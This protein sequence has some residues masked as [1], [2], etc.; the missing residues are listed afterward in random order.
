MRADLQTAYESAVEKFGRE[1]ADRAAAASIEVF[2]TNA[3]AGVSTE[4][5]EAEQLAAF[6]AA[7]QATVHTN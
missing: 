6:E 3:L 2:D 1:V 4:E 7:L 5:C